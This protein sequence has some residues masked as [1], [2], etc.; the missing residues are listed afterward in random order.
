MFAAVQAWQLCQFYQKDARRW[1]GSS[2]Q[3]QESRVGWGTPFRL[4]VDAWRRFRAEQAGK[5]LATVDEP[6]FV[7]DLVA[8]LAATELDVGPL[9]P[10]D[11]TA[12]FVAN[13][14]TPSAARALDEE[15]PASDS[16]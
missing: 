9:E 10:G 5:N 16:D 1:L 8:D 7:P 14:S 2:T 3:L 13:R 12:H 4:I 11:G 6:E 15:R